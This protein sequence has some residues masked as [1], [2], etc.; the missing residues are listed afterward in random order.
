[1][2]P[3][4]LYFGFSFS[5]FLA[6][7][8]QVTLCSDGT[9]TDSPLELRHFCSSAS[10][11]ALANQQRHFRRCVLRSCLSCQVGSLPAMQELYIATDHCCL[12]ATLGCAE[13]ASI[14]L[15]SALGD[16]E[17]SP[18][19]HAKAGNASCSAARENASIVRASRDVSAFKLSPNPPTDS[20]LWGEKAKLDQITPSSALQVA[21]LGAL[22]Q[23]GA[24]DFGWLRY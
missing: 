5:I 1:M 21:L 24:R 17:D 18:A 3:A 14:L 13:S 7:V 9:S 4:R 11:V 15:A 6:L 19:H 10:A 12:E 22:A 20:I 16:T 23:L 2:P 8:L